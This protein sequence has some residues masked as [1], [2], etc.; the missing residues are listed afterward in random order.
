MLFN[1]E[2]DLESYCEGTYSERKFYTFTELKKCK[3]YEEKIAPN[4]PSPAVPTSL[5]VMIRKSDNV[6]L[7]DYDCTL[8]SNKYEEKLGEDFQIKT[9]DEIE[10][11]RGLSP[12]VYS[13]L[14][15]IDE[16]SGL[17]SYQHDET[18]GKVEIEYQT[19]SDDNSVEINKASKDVYKMIKVTKI[20][21][22]N[23]EFMTVY[24][25]KSLDNSQSGLVFYNVSEFTKCCKNVEGLENDKFY[26]I[27]D[28]NE[29]CGDCES[30]IVS[31]FYL[32]QDNCFAQNKISSRKIVYVYCS[33]PSQQTD[34]GFMMNDTYSIE[35]ENYK[36]INGR[37]PN[38][39]PTHPVPK[40]SMLYRKEVLTGYDRNYTLH[41]NKVTTGIDIETDGT[42]SAP[43]SFLLVF[44]ATKTDL[45][46][47][48]SE[49]KYSQYEVGNGIIEDCGVVI[50]ESLKLPITMWYGCP[51]NITLGF[52]SIKELEDICADDLTRI[53]EL[54]N[55]YSLK[56]KVFN[57]GL[58]E[59]N[60]KIAYELN[61]NLMFNDDSAMYTISKDD[62]SNSGGGGG[63]GG[64]SD[65]GNF[66]LP[67]ISILLL[68]MTILLL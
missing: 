24:K 13:S 45:V 63:G 61:A 20:E 37:Y 6:M 65:V 47:G 40:E 58:K 27:S 11:L 64:T 5:C 38:P 7:F 4:L 48:D 49:Y 9:L 51:D 60:G 59:E 53:E 33:D 18:D 16:N 25:V 2:Y 1:T 10:Q 54:I 56:G 21:R 68:L 17:Y 26:S 43:I 55:E 22:K 19:F 14:L 41:D 30:F 28:L 32:G 46:N 34:T 57:I 39:T 62:G 35:R 8:E 66:I 42:L 3:G 31:N 15:P 50:T 52:V 12:P 44:N 67:S 36:M 29:T 23:Y